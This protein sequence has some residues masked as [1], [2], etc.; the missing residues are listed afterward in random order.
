MA[1][2]YYIGLMSGTSVDGVDAV[3]AEFAG[4][5]RSVSA[6]H[7]RLPAA[8]RAE[9]NALQSAG[10]N[11]LHRAALAA[12][13]LM[14]CCAR[15]ALAALER[16]GVAAGQVAAIGV[17]GQT[18]RHRPD[19]GYTL[20]LANAARLAEATGITVVADFR[21]RD[22]A[23]G[24]QGAPLA[25]GMHSALFAVP[26]RHRAVVNLGGIANVTDLPRHGDV[27]GFDTGPGNTL[28]DAWCERHT[29]APFDRDGAWAATGRVVPALLAALE[30]DG[31]FATPPPKST[32]RD[33]FN[34]AWLERHLAA[35][36]R[37]AQAADVQ[38]TLLALTAR[39]VAG[40]IAVHCAGATEVLLCGGGAHS[41]LLRSALELALAPRRVTTTGEFGVPVNEVEALAFAW[42]ARE[43]LAG[44]PASLPG[45]TGARGARILGA[46][47]RA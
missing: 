30:R 40:A 38:R 10:E 33:R 35:L 26:D 15:A 20:Q 23:A 9:L 3:V 44:R 37:P 32:G 14:D 7:E 16:A 11:E 25:P 34:L 21:S 42:L 43:A 47:Y 22:V 41:A 1:P 2:E 18:V 19:L 8:L 39:T 31:Y 46:I 13:A 4:R 12:N 45:V 6:A 29:G 17:H 24:G 27:R 28:L 5:A 36:D